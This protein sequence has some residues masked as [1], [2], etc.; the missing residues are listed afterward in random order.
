MT[1]RLITLSGHC[2][3]ATLLY[4]MCRFKSGYRTDVCER[5]EDMRREQKYSS[6]HSQPLHYMQVN[7]QL[8]ARPIYPRNPLNRWLGGPQRSGVLEKIRFLAPA[9]I[10]TPERS[11]RSLVTIL[12]ELPE[13]FCTIS[14]GC[15]SLCHPLLHF[16]SRWPST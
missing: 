15:I 4:L 11:S 7:G 10:R 3:A 2:A 8:H 14:K 5:H 12:T 16:P 1:D 13:L 6:T 9:G